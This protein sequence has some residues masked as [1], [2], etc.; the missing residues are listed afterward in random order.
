MLCAIG[1]MVDFFYWI[2]NYQAPLLPL[3]LSRGIIQI[4]SEMKNEMMVSYDT[5]YKS[6]VL[7]LVT[8]E[9]TLVADEQMK[10]L[11]NSA[12]LNIVNFPNRSLGFLKSCL[13]LMGTS[14]TSNTLIEQT[15]LAFY[16][17]NTDKAYKSLHE[18][19]VGLL[20][21]DDMSLVTTLTEIANKSGNIEIAEQLTTLIGRKIRMQV[22]SQL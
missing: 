7:G 17:A 11:E 20:N 10:I 13:A 2:T 16:K 1:L 19:N 15:M 3:L 4:S 6:L 21:Y 5:L 12:A 8:G 14:N 9:R 18:I 22:S